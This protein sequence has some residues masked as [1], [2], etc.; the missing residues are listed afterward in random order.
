MSSL[1]DPILPRPPPEREDSHLSEAA[2]PSQKK[3]EARP[4]SPSALEGYT[5]F[6][7]PLGALPHTLRGFLSNWDIRS[8]AGKPYD[9]CSACS[10]E[11]ISLY[12]KDGWE[13]VKRAINERGWVEEISGL[14]EVQRRAE[15]A[16]KDLD[17]DDDEI[18]GDFGEDEEGE[19]L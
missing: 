5:T 14:A 2:E 4:N 11:I 7:H 6:K 1:T 18:G 17:D 19:L 16:M 8:F 3:K 13:F 15:E 12:K 10:N 9:C